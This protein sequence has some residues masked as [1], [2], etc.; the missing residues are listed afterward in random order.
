[1]INDSMIKA[2][3]DQEH[4]KED[5]APNDTNNFNMGG[6]GANLGN[7]PVNMSYQSNVSRTSNNS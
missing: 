5:F 1:M 7:I 2:K 3:L 6:M 4:S